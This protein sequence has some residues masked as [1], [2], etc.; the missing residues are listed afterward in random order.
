MGN[1]QLQV[2]QAA[3][4]ASAFTRAPASVAA[5]SSAASVSGPAV[6]EAPQ[7]DTG[8]PRS[9]LAAAC[10]RLASQQVQA[11]ATAAAALPQD[12]QPS[13]ANFVRC[14]ALCTFEGRG[15]RPTDDASIVHVPEY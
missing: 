14:A 12:V 10:D 1:G 5:P 2:D 8:P 13:S 11:L 15:V 7:V 9:D 3:K 6:S 4:P